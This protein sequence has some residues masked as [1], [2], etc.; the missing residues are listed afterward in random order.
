[1]LR[2]PSVPLDADNTRRYLQDAD[3]RIYDFITDSFIDGCASLRLG[4]RLPF[5]FADWDVDP[6]WK[7]R[8]AGLLEKIFAYWN[9]G[10]GPSGKTLEDGDPFG[11]S[12]AAQFKE[13]VAEGP[14]GYWPLVLAV[15]K[16]NVDEALWQ[17]LHLTAD[18][19][20]LA[21]RCEYT[22]QYGPGGT[23]KDTLHIIKN[24]FFGN[25]SQGGYSTVMPATWFTSKHVVNP[26]APS[27]TLDQLRC[28][29]YAGNNEIPI[30]TWF[31]ADAV[32][33]LCEQQG[34][35]LISRGLYKDPE[36]WRPMAGLGLTGNHPLIL[37]DEQC[38]D[39]GNRRRLN[40]LKM[41]ARF[42][43]SKQK[44]VKTMINAGTLNTE[45][46]WLVRRIFPY[47]MSNEG[48]RLLPRPPRVIKETTQLLNQSTQKKIIA[49]LIEH[50]KPAATYSQAS[51]IKEVKDVFTKAFKLTASEWTVHAHAIGLQQKVSGGAGRVWVYQ[52]P[53]EV[54]MRAVHLEQSAF[55][56]A[57]AAA[58]GEADDEEA[59]QEAEDA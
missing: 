28:M 58:A 2:Q 35:W 9:A 55:A 51:G 30:H 29:R 44:D 39:G 56:A 24:N 7:R 46:L 23:G 59:D 1:M 50:T 19:C 11:K 53:D 26:D 12:L 20:A 10:S 52:Y 16:N 4:R 57:T 42:P 37:S 32:K 25:R 36:P 22:Y 8:F 31:N 34:T 21:R 18:A 3:G 5:S 27:T 15:Y 49:F 13:L 38:A 43:E 14:S 54:A 33:P 40:Y 48:S 17:T 45:I 6:E 41:L 47:L